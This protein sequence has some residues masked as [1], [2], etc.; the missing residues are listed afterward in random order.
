MVCTEMRMSRGPSTPAAIASEQTRTSVALVALSRSARFHATFGSAYHPLRSSAPLRDLR[1]A[2]HSTQ[3]PRP[4]GRSQRSRHV[5]AITSSETL[6]SCPFMRTWRAWN[7]PIMRRRSLPKKSRALGT[8]SNSQPSQSSLT[9]PTLP[10]PH[11]RSS[12]CSFT[13]RTVVV[14][15]GR[16][17]N[18]APSDARRVDMESSGEYSSSNGAPSVESPAWRIVIA[19]VHPLAMT[20]QAR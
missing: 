1:Q 15:L 13:V 12:V 6:P 4:F 10:R 18:V 7:S 11:S 16:L 14:T 2:S 3:S 8:R 17:P 20:F 5:E 19:S 9:A